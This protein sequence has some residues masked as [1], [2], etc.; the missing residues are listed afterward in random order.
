M[1]AADCVFS[2]ACRTRLDAFGA[3]RRKGGTVMS[4]PDDPERLADVRPPS[5][6]GDVFA[7]AARDLP[8]DAQ[9][10][11]LAAKLGPVLDGPEGTSPKPSNASTL[12][13]LGVGT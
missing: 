1:S 10:A 6:L 9:L 4:M 5:Q 12:V 11:E 7:S 8:S 2:L 3:Q 13:K